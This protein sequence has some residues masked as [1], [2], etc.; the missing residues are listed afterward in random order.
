MW[1]EK[2]KREEKG[3]KESREGRGQRNVEKTGV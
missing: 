1:K 2:A 3:S